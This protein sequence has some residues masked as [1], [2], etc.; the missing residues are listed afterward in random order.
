M[1]NYLLTGNRTEVVRAIIA[2]IN[3]HPEEW[4]ASRYQV[5]HRSGVSVWIGNSHY[6]VDISVDGAK[7]LG[8]VTAASS[9]FGALIPWRRKILRA[10]RMLNPPPI[11]PIIS[12]S[13]IVQR[14]AP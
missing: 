11:R 1:R 4:A 5:T 13:A 6:G 14:L 12:A 9:F 8:G 2:S 7:V 3:D 10:A